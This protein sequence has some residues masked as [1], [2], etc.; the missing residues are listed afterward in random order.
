[1][2]KRI[3]ATFLYTQASKPKLVQ[4]SEVKTR[5][6]FNAHLELEKKTKKSKVKQCLEMSFSLVQVTPDIIEHSTPC[7]WSLDSVWLHSWP[8]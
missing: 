8:I 7:V 4:H 1:M 3:I 6:S 5:V 2:S